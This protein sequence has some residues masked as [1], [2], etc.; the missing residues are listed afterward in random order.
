VNGAE[1]GYAVVDTETTGFGAAD[2]VIEIG[3]V[4]LDASLALEGEW[5]TLVNPGAR[6]LGP[7]AVHRIRPADVA[8]APDFAAVAGRLVGLVRGRVLVGHNVGFDARMLNQEFERLGVGRPVQGQFS[9]DTVRLTRAE[10]LSPNGVYTLDQLCAHFRIERRPA[11]AALADARATAELLAR[12]A[13][14][15]LARLG[16]PARPDALWPRQWAAAEAA[17]W[18]E[19]PVV[20]APRRSRLAAGAA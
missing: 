18:P 9:L 7:T 3:V 1:T 2:R 19:L 8:D 14:A 4:L 13:A 11:H 10:A 6:S 5:D 16:R 12:A 20:A 15:G 17:C